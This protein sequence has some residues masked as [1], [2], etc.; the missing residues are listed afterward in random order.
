[1][2]V[3]VVVGTPGLGKTVLAMHAAHAL[4]RNFPDGQLFV[5]LLGASEQ[6][7]DAR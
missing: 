3:A 7:V 1:M 4:R 6:P 2:N 5:S